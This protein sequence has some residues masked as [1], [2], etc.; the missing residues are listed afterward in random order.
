MSTFQ[1]VAACIIGVVSVARLTRLITQDS[2][3]PVAWLR[4]QWERITHD[5]E[6]SALATCP[7]CAAPYI[8]AVVLAWGLLTEFQVAWWVVNG[9]LAASYLAS[10]VVVR[11]G[12]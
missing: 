5:G 10:M 12:E 1:I 7:Y 4:S 3:P 2:Y 11:D 6:W 9:W 8:A